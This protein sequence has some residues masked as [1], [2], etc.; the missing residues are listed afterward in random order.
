MTKDIIAVP[1]SLWVGA[2][3]VTQ[4]APTP[5]QRMKRLRVDDGFG[6]T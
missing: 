2:G 5:E 1:G 6:E 3:E 4:T